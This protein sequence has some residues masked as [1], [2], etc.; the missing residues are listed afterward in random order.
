[1]VVAAPLSK[2]TICHHADD[3]RR[4]TLVVGENS[5]P[6]HLQHGDTLGT[7]DNVCPCQPSIDP[8]VCSN[9][10]T[11]INQC[12]ATCAGQADCDRACPCQPFLDPV[13]CSNGSTYINQCVATCREATDCRPPCG[14]CP[15]TGNTVLCTTGNLYDNQCKGLCA[16]EDACWYIDN[17]VIC[18]PAVVFPPGSCPGFSPVICPNGASYATTCVAEACLHGETD[19]CTSACLFGANVCVQRDPVT[20][21]NGKTYTNPCFAACDG[22]TGC[23]P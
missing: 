1:M 22:A 15:E 8:V 2:I 14:S 11:Y 6:A 12:V 7:C 10:Q 21:A 4:I 20:C 5:L 18:D 17:R 3:N 23:A 16:G 9:G 13:V 19:G